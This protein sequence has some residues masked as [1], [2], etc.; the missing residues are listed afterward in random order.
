MKFDKN[1]KK[2]RKLKFLV[3]K[4]VA[5]GSLSSPQNF[6]KS[7]LTSKAVVVLDIFG[8]YVMAARGFS[9][10]GAKTAIAGQR[11]VSQEISLNMICN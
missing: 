10:R 7:H 9:T 3:I 4:L 1:K 5:N 6:Q 11:Y 2:S 8:L